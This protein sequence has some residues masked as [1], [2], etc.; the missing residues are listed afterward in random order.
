MAEDGVTIMGKSEEWVGAEN[1]GLMNAHGNFNW[2][3]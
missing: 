3:A 2:G 1:P